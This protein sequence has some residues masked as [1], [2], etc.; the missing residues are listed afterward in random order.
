[1]KDFSE[2][3][4]KFQPKIHSYLCKLA[5][6][7]D[8]PDLTQT[9]FLKVSQSLE[10]FRGESSL[11]TWIFRIATNVALDRSRSPLTLELT[12]GSSDAAETAT[13]DFWSGEI[14]PA[15][16]RQLIRHEM[17]ACIREVV[18]RLPPD[19]RSVL[20]L[21]EQEELKDAEIATILGVSLS[22]VKIRLHRARAKLREALE[23]SCTFYHD[24]RSELA[25]NRKGEN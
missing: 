14:P 12:N 4:Q 21:S 3:Y 2:I 18:D 1:M 16:D 25:C 24:E 8:A 13:E 11:A 22:T 9:V 19:F 15:V 10:G 6:E 7:A 23:C 17:N 20:L 5:G